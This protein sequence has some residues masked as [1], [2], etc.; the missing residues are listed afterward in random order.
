MIPEIDIRDQLLERHRLVLETL[1][2]MSRRF[3][4][5]QWVLVGGL[6]V[7]VVGR[8]HEARAPRA[9][10]T[11]DAD[12]V[13]DVVAVPDLLGLIANFLVA[14]NHYTLADTIGTGDRPARCSFVANSAQ[15]DVLCPDDVSENMLDA[16]D[17]LRSLAIPGGRR[18]LQTARPVELLFSDSYPPAEIHVPD[19]LGAF[20][21]KAAAAVDPRTADS[22]RHIQDVAFLLTMF[23]D[24]RAATNRLL[25][26]DWDVLQAIAPQLEDDGSAA[27]RYL[28]PDLRDLARSAY[29]LFFS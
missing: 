28:D 10:G 21:V 1:T 3:R 8:E 14:D 18:A 4:P 9:E 5:D 29:R 24:P 6:M 23:D 20:V 2:L 7:M 12:V 26:A 27:W 16:G 19:L 22:P 25:P 11:K 15:I 13:V 17:D